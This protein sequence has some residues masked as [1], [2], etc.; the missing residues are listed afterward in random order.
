M[1]ISSKIKK[2]AQ[3][4]LDSFS[5]E[6]AKIDKKLS[7]EKLVEREKGEREEGSGKSQELDREI[8]FSNA[9]NKSKDFIVG[10]RGG[11]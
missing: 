8:M 3:D 2:E 4:I 7:K 5:K 1:E 10:E 9:P 6:L 11:W